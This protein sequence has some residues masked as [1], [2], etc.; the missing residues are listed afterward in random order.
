V[1]SNITSPIRYNYDLSAFAGQTIYVAIRNVSVD[2]YYQFVDNVI[3]PMPN[4]PVFI[5]EVYYDGPGTD[6]GMF[7]E[8]FGK[9]GMK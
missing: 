5:N 6:T 8:L 2:M 4:Y 3:M 9:P 7:T 1:T